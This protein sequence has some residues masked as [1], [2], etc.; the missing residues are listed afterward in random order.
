MQWNRFQ[1]TIAHDDCH[2]ECGL[3]HTSCLCNDN[4]TSIVLYTIH[5]KSDVNDYVNKHAVMRVINVKVVG[6]LRQP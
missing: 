2:N 4:V 6:K 5:L 1:Q 3:S